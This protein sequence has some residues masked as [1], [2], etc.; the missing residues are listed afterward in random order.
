MASALRT[1][2]LG[3]V[4]KLLGQRGCWAESIVPLAM[5][6]VAG[7]VDGAH[8]GVG[9]LDAGGIGVL[10]ELAA[11]REAG[12]GGR[13]GDQLDDDL[14]ADEWFAAPIAGDERE[15]AM[16]DLV[17]LACTGRQVTHGDGNGEFIGQLLQLDLPQSDAR[18]PHGEPVEPCC[19]RHRR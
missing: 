14:V 17:P 5:E 10:I 19:R 12:L 6:V 13:R 9:H 2:S 8:L 15:Q 7:E 3:P 18:T 11:N 4:R 16:L 1:A